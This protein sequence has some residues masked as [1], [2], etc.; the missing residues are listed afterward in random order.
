MTFKLNNNDKTRVIELARKLADN[1]I[2]VW[3]SLN[4]NSMGDCKWRFI[5]S[6]SPNIFTTSPMAIVNGGVGALINDL[7]EA[8]FAHG[9]MK[10]PEHISNRNHVRL[11]FTPT[12]GNMTWTT[13]NG[14]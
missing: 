8:C 14:G 1:D 11:V 7:K 12:N 4:P 3:I 6:R 5:N 9:I 10:R 13:S 2:K